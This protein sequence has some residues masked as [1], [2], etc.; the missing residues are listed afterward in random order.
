MG[1][2]GVWL[3]RVAVCGCTIA[4]SRSFVAPRLLPAGDAPAFRLL[5]ASRPCPRSHR[6]ALACQQGPRQV[7]DVVGYVH[8][9]KYQFSE[10][11]D[12]AGKS[13]GADYSAASGQ[14]PTGKDPVPRWA[15]GTFLPGKRVQGEVRLV[16]PGDTAEVQIINE[17][18]LAATRA[19]CLL[20]RTQQQS[21]P[22]FRTNRVP[23]SGDFVGTLLRAS[24]GKLP[25]FNG[26]PPRL[27]PPPHAA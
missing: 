21:A 1:R 25:R 20:Q 16:S 15:Q 10:G 27:P 2:C 19:F 26:M 24:C 12:S 11:G 18:R 4:P 8:G 23:F 7:G 14:G 22:R 9:G 17:V 5:S 6:V 3:L 13:L